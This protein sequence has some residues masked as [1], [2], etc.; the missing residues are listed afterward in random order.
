MA[1]EHTLTT[2]R[3]RIQTAQYAV[4]LAEERATAAK[5][6]LT[7]AKDEYLTASLTAT[8]SHPVGFQAAVMAEGRTCCA[9]SHP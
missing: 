4:D 6:Q 8:P 7:E 1:T 5:K 9:H 2:L 3:D